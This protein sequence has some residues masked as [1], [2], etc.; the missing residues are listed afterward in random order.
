MLFQSRD[1]LSTVSSSK[2]NM[3]HSHDI[4][5]SAVHMLLSVKQNN[6]LF[7]AH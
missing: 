4:Y 1:A 7:L 5:F 3:S 2:C 6:A